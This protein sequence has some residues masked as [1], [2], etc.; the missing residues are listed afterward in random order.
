[1]KAKSLLVI[2]SWVELGIAQA[3]HG[4]PNR[5]SAQNIGK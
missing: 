5:D 2:N 4:P 1:M 3:A